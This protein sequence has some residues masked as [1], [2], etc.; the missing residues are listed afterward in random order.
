MISFFVPGVPVTQGSKTLKGRYM[1][2]ASGP[3]LKAWRTAV[4]WAARQAHRGPP[5]PLSTPLAVTLNFTFQRPAKPSR[6]YPCTSGGQDIEK[7]VRAVHDAL[8][9]IVWTDDSQC[10]DIRAIKTYG[11]RAGVSVE[12]RQA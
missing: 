1:A 7:L 9:G 10:V 5:A 2:E 4:G 3:R 11:E 6:G 8:T 12:V